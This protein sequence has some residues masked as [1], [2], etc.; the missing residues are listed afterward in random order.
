[1]ARRCMILGGGTAGLAVGHFARRAGLPCT[2]FEAATQLGGNART[3]HAKLAA[4]EFRYD[5]GAHR[6][7][8]PDPEVTAEVRG[9]LGDELRQVSAPSRI[10][11]RGRLVDFP[12]RG[13]NLLHAL[14]LPFCL[15][16]GARLGWARMF[17]PGEG[18]DF[19]SMALRTYGSAV[20]RP[21]LLD[22]S[23]KLWGRPGTQLSPAVAGRRLRGLHLRS[24]LREMV[25]GPGERAGTLEGAFHYPR[26]GIGRLAEALADS[27]G[28]DCLHPATPVTGI[29]HDGRRITALRI[30]R[31]EIPLDAATDLV[32]STLPLHLL[33]ELLDPTP[34]DAVLAAA[35]S[36][37]FRDVVLV[38]VFLDR[39]VVTENA[40]V[41]F[42]GSEFPFTRVCEPRNRSG[43]MAPA[44]KTS[45]VAEIPVESGPFEDQL[46]SGDDAPPCLGDERWSGPAI[47]ALGSIGWV[48]RGEVLGT[49][50]H[51]IRHAYPVLDL[52]IE[53]RLAVAVDWL[54][55]LG[56]L[57]RAGRAGTFTY[58]HLHDH[59]GEARDLVA[60]ASAGASGL[61]L[62]DEL[63]GEDQ[64]ARGA[65]T[66]SRA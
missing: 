10:Y 41:Y 51:R 17:P 14:G 11:H 19:A 58:S 56:N 61:F 26:T 40:T 30:Q 43:S 15:Q 66:G 46:I 49:A 65:T 52:G 7:H 45:L 59:L 2:L 38:A 31:R 36:L 12:L 63:R 62:P 37:R 29:R 9:L 50:V 34:P 4:G 54:S 1:V 13:G 32:V 5:T 18:R 27:A 20:A 35:R 28:K 53:S 48:R 33:L 6:I 22:Y 39:E 16:A 21:F 47:V 8:G 24:F 60:A 3:L 64:V 25:L 42:P 57:R 44:G 23:E 55:R